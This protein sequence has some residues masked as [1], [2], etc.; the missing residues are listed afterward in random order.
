MKIQ[1]T[2]QQLVAYKKL[3]ENGSIPDGSKVSIH[4]QEIYCTV[5]EKLTYAIHSSGIVTEHMEG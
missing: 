2:E 3:R 4:T 1:P 5:N